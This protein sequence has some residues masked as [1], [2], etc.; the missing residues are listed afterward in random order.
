MAKRT[1]KKYTY[2]NTYKHTKKSCSINSA[3]FV[4]YIWPSFNFFDI[5]HG[6]VSSLKLFCFQIHFS[7][8]Y[9][10]EK[11]EKTFWGGGGGIKWNIAHLSDYVLETVS[12]KKISGNICQYKAVTLI[13]KWSLTI[14]RQIYLK[15]TL[16]SQ[17][18]FLITPKNLS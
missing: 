1:Y 14:W 16:K 10:L 4:K 12:A 13:Y 5:I 8:T 18:N 11:P 15:I 7:Q 2:K 6:R 3:R 17:L 9:N